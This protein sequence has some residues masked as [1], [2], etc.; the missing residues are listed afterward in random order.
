MDVNVVVYLDE[1]GSA[2][3]ISVNGTLREVNQISLPKDNDF[4]TPGVVANVLYKKRLI[5]Y[6]VSTGVNSDMPL[7]STATYNLTVG[8]LDSPVKGENVSITARLVGFRSEELDSVMT[9][10][11]IP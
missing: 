11:E 5:G 3:I 7:N 8:L 2:K 9:T 4:V 10:F 1:E 6:W